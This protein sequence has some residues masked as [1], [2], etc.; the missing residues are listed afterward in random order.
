[1]YHTLI[2]NECLEI[3]PEDI[4]ERFA[5]QTRAMA[6][7]NLRYTNAL[8]TILNQFEAQDIPVLPFKGPTLSQVVY[9]EYVHRHYRDID[10]VVPPT[11]MQLA[12]SVLS[13][14]GYESVREMTPRQRRHHFSSA[15]SIELQRDGVVIELHQRLT[16]VPGDIV[17]T[18]SVIDRSDSIKIEGIEVPSLQPLDRLLLLCAHGTRH[19]WFRLKWL[20][21][22]TYLIARHDFDWSA[23][24]SEAQQRQCLRRLLFG[25][26]LVEIIFDVDLPPAVAGVVYSDSASTHQYLVDRTYPQRLIRSHDPGVIDNLK[27]QLASQDSLISGL[28]S[29]W[30]Y[31][32]KPTPQEYTRVDLPTNLYHLYYIFRAGYAALY[33]WKQL[34]SQSSRRGSDT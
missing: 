17:E 20:C 11:H 15:K 8:I 23:V 18:S 4:L 30:W 27:H 10:I 9:G 3:L 1:M 12:T 2:N 32:M 22:V 34:C 21:D 28:Q 29:C 19:H 33:G 14:M 26:S 31:K 25:L 6:T 24:L 7:Q 16:T 13:D 5:I